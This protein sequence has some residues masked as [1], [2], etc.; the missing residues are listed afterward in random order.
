MKF[1]TFQK[2]KRQQGMALILAIGFLAVLS[3]LGAVVMRVSTQD[4]KSS[5]LVV[6]AQKAFYV[7]DRAVEYALNRDMIYYLNPMGTPPTPTAD[8]VNGTVSSG[9]THK[10]IIEA[11]E[12][13]ISLESGKVEDLGASFLPP[14]LASVHGS[15]FGANL[16][17]VKVKTMA[18]KG[19]TNLEAAAHVDAAIIRLYKKDDDQ[20]FRTSGEG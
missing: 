5:G 1:L 10:E 2:N 8:L 19:N 16:Y 7:A 17:H 6:P 9:T 3:I 14:Y 18:N 15:D 20:I 11:G 4:M 12:D 13:K